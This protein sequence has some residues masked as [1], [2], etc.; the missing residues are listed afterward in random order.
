MSRL[1]RKYMR[2]R[3]FSKKTGIRCVLFCLFA[4]IHFTLLAQAPTQTTLDENGIT[5][6]FSASRAGEQLDFFA[7]NLGHLGVYSIGSDGV[8]RLNL[9]RVS[10]RPGVCFFAVNSQSQ[11]LIRFSAQNGFRNPFWEQRGTSAAQRQTDRPVAQ[12]EK[13]IRDFEASLVDARA[14]L[15]RE[16][17]GRYRNGQCFRAAVRKRTRPAFAFEGNG[18]A[19]YAA[20]RCERVIASRP[21]SCE[22]VLRRAELDDNAPFLAPQ[23]SSLM[24]ASLQIVAGPS[25]KTDAAAHDAIA[26]R[27]ADQAVTDADS[28][29]RLAGQCI[30][31][32]RQASITLL[33]QWREERD[34]VNGEEDRA[35]AGCTKALEI[36]ADETI[37]RQELAEELAAARARDASRPKRGAPAAASRSASAYPCSPNTGS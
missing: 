25:D 30:A 2:A 19:I 9:S 31:E 15:A 32:I 8:I 36:I 1:L 33:N 18:A 27:Y 12:I 7:I 10:P 11:M 16:E 4:S 17:G 28:R 24:S 3:Y 35:F 26:T 37:L 5:L 6:K 20:R 22:A 21:L 14:T 13:D 23:C 29:P 34:R